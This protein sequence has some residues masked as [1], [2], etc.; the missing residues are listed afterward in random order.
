MASTA[1]VNA[2]T[3]VMASEA[4]PSMTANSGSGLP[5]CARS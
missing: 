3:P 1:F 4:W 2:K 5:R